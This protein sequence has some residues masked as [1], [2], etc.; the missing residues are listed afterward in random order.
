MTR[1]DAT[2]RDSEALEEGLLS[3]LK[4]AVFRSTLEGD[5]LSANQSFAVML[6][7]ASIEQAIAAGPLIPLFRRVGSEADASRTEPIEGAIRNAHGSEIW[8]SAWTAL[9][10]DEPG[11]VEGFFADIT[12]SKRMQIVRMEKDAAARQAEKLDSLGRLCG[13]VAHEFNNLLTAITGYSEL[14]LLSLGADSPVRQD[15]LEIRSAGIRAT[16]LT[17][18]LLALGRRQFFQ[19]RIVDLNSVVLAVDSSAWCNSMG[20]EFKLKLEDPLRPILADPVQMETII[21][22]LVCNARDALPAGGVVEISTGNVDIGEERAIQDPQGDFTWIGESILPGRYVSLTVADNG[23]G[24]APDMLTRV[25]DPFF[26][27]KHQS[28]SAGLG[29][30]TVYGIVKQSEGHIAVESVPGKGATFRVLLPAA[31]G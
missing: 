6:G 17:S 5:V 14:L 18:E 9:S 3:R 28:K 2:G 26:T 22:N 21:A 29:L 25:F 11:V 13:G 8:I 30:S 27:T 20:I 23:A 31:P 16:R 15:V 19:N 12:R 4:L 24:I 10:P 7:Y 1:A